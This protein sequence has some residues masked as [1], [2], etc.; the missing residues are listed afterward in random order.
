[1]ELS[2]GV[3]TINFSLKNKQKNTWWAVDPI[4]IMIDTLF[5]FLRVQLDKWL[6]KLFVTDSL[7]DVV[8]IRFGKN[9]PPKTYFLSLGFLL[10]KITANVLGFVMQCLS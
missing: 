4:R 5:V 3:H 1:M 2:K 9:L 6:W 10:L 7:D 8:L